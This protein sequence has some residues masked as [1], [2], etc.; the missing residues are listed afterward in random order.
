MTYHNN[1]LELIGN[2]PL[3]KLNKM[4]AGIEATVLLKLESRNPGGSVKDRI[5]ISMIEAAEREGRLK[6][7]GLIIE[8]TS[9]NTGIGIA[10]VARLKGY[11]C[12]FVMTD[13]AS[14]ERV[15]Y[16]KALGADVLVVS[17]AAKSN[18]PEYYF[19]T[20]QRLAAEL[21]NAIMLNQYDFYANPAAHERTTGPEIWRDT[22]GKITH[23]ISGIGTGGTI[24][25][26]ARFLKRQNPAIKVIGADPPAHPLKPSKI[27]D[28]SSKRC[29][30][31][32]KV[33]GRN[34]SPAI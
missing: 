19:N 6:P 20:A 13:K 22:D 10:L 5:G 18:S 1:I 30:I 21:P 24:T 14:G 4:A 28:A 29:R 23:F 3:V 15:K 33:S 26:T 31:L 8:P 11:R 25:G 7:G 9:G 12:L 32:S 17:S 16:L 27:P 2:T 34:V